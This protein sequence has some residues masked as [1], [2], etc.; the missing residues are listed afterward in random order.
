MF[1]RTINLPIW[2]SWLLA[3]CTIYGAFSLAADIGQLLARTF[4][5]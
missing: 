2:A 5:R 1:E 3:L 4:M